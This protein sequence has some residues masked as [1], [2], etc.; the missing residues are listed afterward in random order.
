MSRSAR[1]VV[2]KVA[3][4][5]PAGGLVEMEMEEERRFLAREVSYIEEGALVCELAWK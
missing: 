5:V 4:V 3:A 1:V 2:G